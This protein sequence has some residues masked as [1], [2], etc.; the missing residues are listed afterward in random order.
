[1]HEKVVENLAAEKYK[2]IPAQ[3]IFM[4]P[5]LIETKQTKYLLSYKQGM[6]KEKK[7]KK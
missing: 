6:I 1:M 2:R 5:F 4:W 7:K 3:V